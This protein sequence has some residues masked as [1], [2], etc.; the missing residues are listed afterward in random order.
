MR[1]VDGFTRCPTCTVNSLFQQQLF[2][3]PIFYLIKKCESRNKE[4][5]SQAST[6]LHQQP[7]ILQ[8]K[9]PLM[10]N[11][12]IF[13]SFT[14]VFSATLPQLMILIH[15][16]KSQKVLSGE[17]ISSFLWKKQSPDK[18]NCELNCG[19]L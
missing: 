9:W 14:C 16:H 4:I 15:F 5:S 12:L 8:T 6:Q 13:N 1:P 2:S 3:P 19:I 11:W 17:K 7:G 10:S 18:K